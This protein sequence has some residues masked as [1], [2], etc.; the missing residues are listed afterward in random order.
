M[1][2]L[3]T[4]AKLYILLGITTL[5]VLVFFALYMKDYV[6]YYVD[7]YSFRER[8]V[9]SLTNDETEK[10]TYFPGD[11]YEGNPRARI[12]V[13]EYG[14][15]SCEACRQLQGTLTELRR[16][17]GAQNMMV[18]WK[19]LPITIAPNNLLAHQAAHCA[20]DQNAFPA[21]KPLLYD[22]QAAF[23]KELFVQL[24]QQLNLDV[25][26]FTECLDTEKHKST[27]TGNF[28]DALRIGLDATPTLF[29]NNREVQSGFNFENLRNIIEQT[30]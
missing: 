28:N 13:F 19:D 3:T 4:N 30:K 23:S 5:L 11:P 20:N 1:K 25:A 27:V 22:N 14:D 26:V 6:N 16:F 8:L 10:P 29:I 24:A 18:V 9:N 15:F 2:E 12:V 17:Y 21:Y 7:L